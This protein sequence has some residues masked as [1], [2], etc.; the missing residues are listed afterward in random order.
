MNDKMKNLVVRT[1]SGVA[2]L[3]V[4]FGGILWSQWSLGALLLLMLVGG[5]VCSM[6]TT[7]FFINIL[8][9]KTRIFFLP[10]LHKISSIVC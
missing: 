3:V 2:L 9:F 5:V 7:V 6:H 4:V 1:L 10:L 8:Y